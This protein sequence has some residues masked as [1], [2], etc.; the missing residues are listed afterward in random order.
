MLGTFI[1][2][3]FGV[4]ILIAFIV[5]ISAGFSKQFSKPLCGLIA[6]FVAIILTALIH[7]LIA[8][9][10]FYIGLEEKA[11]GLFTADFYTQQATDVDSLSAILSSGYLRI[12][13]NVADKLWANMQAMEVSTLG[14]YFGKL[15]VK[16]VAQFIIWLVLYLAIKYLLFGIKYL[17]SKISQVVVF[18]SIDKILGIVWSFLLTYIIVVGIVLSVGELVLVKFL[19]NVATTVTDIVNQTALTK[20]FHNINVIG[21]F[22]ADMLGWELLPVV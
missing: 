16:V 12:L 4:I 17:M 15:L 20:F 9:L 7:S 8:P 22:I 21:S 2:V 6:I 5:G 11:I 14:V 18:K 3:G 19:P 13:V 1:D 10:G